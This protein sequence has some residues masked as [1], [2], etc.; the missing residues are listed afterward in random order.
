MGL[1]FARQAEIPCHTVRRKDF[2]NPERTA[3]PSSTCAVN[4]LC[5]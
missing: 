1:N 5:S 3:R 2:D 4:M